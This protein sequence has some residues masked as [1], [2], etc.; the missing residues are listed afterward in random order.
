[1]KRFNIVVNPTVFHK[2]DLPFNS[3]YG[4]LVCDITYLYAVSRTRKNGNVYRATVR[5]VEKKTVSYHIINHAPRL[6]NG[7]VFY[8]MYVFI[9]NR[10]RKVTTY[11]KEFAPIYDIV[12]D[13]T[14]DRNLKRATPHVTHKHSD[15]P[16]EKKAQVDFDYRNRNMGY[17]DNNRTVT[18]FD[19]VAKFRP[20]VTH[21]GFAR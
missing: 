2:K 6:E 1:M 13:N 11:H 12:Y 4:A 7:H 8:D 9:D 19:P 17:A 10:W 3:I 14:H 21:T 20:F 16:R 18:D 15:G 5:R